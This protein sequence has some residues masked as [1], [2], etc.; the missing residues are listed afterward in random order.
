MQPGEGQLH[1]GLHAGRTHYPASRTR[2]PAGQVVKQHGLAYA[3]LA[4]HHQGLAFTGPHPGHEPVKHAT[5]AEPAG[6][7]RHRAPVARPGMNAHA[8]LQP[9]TTNA[10]GQPNR[11]ARTGETARPAA[12]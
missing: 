6:Q 11:G 7:P 12:I 5:F 10:P 4:A 8:A 1:F 2:G 3:R 9:A